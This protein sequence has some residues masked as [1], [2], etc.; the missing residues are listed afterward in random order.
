[1][2]PPSDDLLRVSFARSISSSVAFFSLASSAR[3]IARISSSSSSMSF[4]SASAV[5]FAAFA[6]AAAK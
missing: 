4:S 2:N 1:M 3:N 5:G 6:R